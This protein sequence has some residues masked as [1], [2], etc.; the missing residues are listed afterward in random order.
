MY[1]LRTA[2]I[3]SAIAVL[4]G[5]QSYNPLA[6][7]GPATVPAPGS[8]QSQPYYP[9]SVAKTD[10]ATASASTRPSVSA[11]GGPPVAVHGRTVTA[12]AGDREPIRVVENSSPTRT[13]AAPSRGNSPAAGKAA[14]PASTP[15]GSPA[16]PTNSL[17]SGKPTSSPQSRLQADPMVAP[18]SYQPSPAAF[19]ARPAETGQWRAR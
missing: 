11:E 19:S 1:V 13:A 12:D 14:I 10:R 16:L 7:F 4:P 2:L 18:A 17:P 8:S 3:L 6:V 5:C 15:V 9:P